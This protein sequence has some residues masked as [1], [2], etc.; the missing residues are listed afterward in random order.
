MMPQASSG[1]PLLLQENQI[2]KL[3][4][5]LLL[6]TISVGTMAAQEAGAGPAGMRPPK[7]TSPELLPDGRVTF[8]LRAPKATAVLVEGNWAG[9]KDVP[10]SKDDGGVWSVTVAALPPELW[11]YTYSVDGLRVLDPSS[12][13]VARDGIFGFQNT[14]VVTGD[15]PSEVRARVVP[16]G[17][18]EEIWVPSTAL[19]TPRRTMIYLPPGYEDGKARYPVL[20]LLHGSGGDEEAWPTMGV[21]NVIMDNL[22]AEGKAKPMIVVMPNAYPDQVAALDLGGPVKPSSR[23]ASLSAPAGSANAIVPAT[24]YTPNEKDLVVDLVPFVDSHFRTISKPDGRALAGLSMGG[25]IT[26]GVGLKRPD[27]FAYAGLFST[28][29]FRMA[30]TP[31]DAISASAPN[32]LTSAD[33]TNKNYKLVFFSVGTDDPRMPSTT[34]VTDQLRERNFHLVYKIYPGSHEWKVWRT[35]LIDF[36]T[37]LFR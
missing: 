33:A 31:M 37:L 28:G 20:Y 3:I 4:H 7:L 9:G 17:T 6:A 13:N 24:D 5:A 14:F 36:A 29:N 15:S 12:N 8:R 2:M 18:V 10:M 27:I 16:H 35:S 25:G 22:I 1:F 23:L 11:T 21:A 32:F 26:L 30:A 19:K 34:I